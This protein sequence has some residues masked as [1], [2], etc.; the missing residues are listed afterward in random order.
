MSNA[1]PARYDGRCGAC[2]ERIYEGDMIEFSGE[3]ATNFMHTDC[4]AAAPPERVQQP[5]CP[6]C[7]TELPVTGACGVCE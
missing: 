5:I 3:S 4:A 2:D 6:R 7:Y 1:F